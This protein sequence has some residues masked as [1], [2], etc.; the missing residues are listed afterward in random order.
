MGIRVECDW[1]RKPIEA[2]T[3]YVTIEI[4]GKVRG[5]RDVG[6][7]ARVF[8]GDGMGDRSCGERLLA[9]LD[10]NPGGPVD[11]GMEWRLVPIGATVDAPRAPVANAPPI[12]V[13]SDSDLWDF[14]ATL[15]P[16]PRHKLSKALALA[17][18][19]ALDEVAALSDDDLMAI[20]GVGWKTRCALRAFI[21]A[22]KAA[23]D[24]SVTA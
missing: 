7:A 20:D 13:S 6:G 3:P 4:D 2:A 8:C 19:T 18:I 24:E 16:S 1:C 21:A 9:L 5:G 17:G 10:G 11:M 22:R 23:L 15:T 14:L 12:A